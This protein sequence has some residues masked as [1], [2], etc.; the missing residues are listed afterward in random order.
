MIV[1][2]RLNVSGR[3][4]ALPEAALDVV[5][6]PFF[7]REVILET[8]AL[9]AA[10]PKISVWLDP[11]AMY[12]LM[13]RADLAV[14]GGGQ[15]TYEL[16]ASGTPAVAIRLVGN[17][18]GN[19]KGLSACGVLEWVDGVDDADLHEKVQA[20]IVRLGGDP[21]AREAMS[22]AGR[23]LVDGQG[24]ARVARAVLEICRN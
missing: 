12:E 13:A 24:A 11:P 20:A 19:L 18:T 3:L 17:Q 14:T 8:E 9:A 1:P 22:R 6:G 15:T 10:N 21:L 16:A 4:L 5:T 7:S 2:G 23:A